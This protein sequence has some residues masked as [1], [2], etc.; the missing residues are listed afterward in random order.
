MVRTVC[1]E[2]RRMR[3]VQVRALRDWPVGC[4]CRTC[5]TSKRRPIRH[6]ACT[7]QRTTSWRARGGSR[8]RWSC[9]PGPKKTTEDHRRLYIYMYARVCV[10]CLCWHIGQVDLAGEPGT[11]FAYNSLHLQLAG[12]IAVSLVAGGSIQSVVKKYLLEPYGMSQTSCGGGGANPQLAVCL[13]TTGNGKHT[14]ART[15]TCTH[16]AHTHAHARL[17]TTPSR[18]HTRQCQRQRQ[19]PRRLANA[20]RTWKRPG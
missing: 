6:C 8:T 3:R 19:E 4:Q 13:T 12:S 20:R 7:T 10:A 15:R 1:N 11:V 18:S 9:A 2:E 16:V 17:C 14:H 5:P